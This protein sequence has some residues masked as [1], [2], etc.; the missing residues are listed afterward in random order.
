M[1]CSLP[2]RLLC[3]WNSPGKNTGMSSLSV[4]QGIFPSQG[5]NLGLPHCRWILYQLSHKGSP[6]IQE[7]VAVFFSSGSSR[8]RDWTQVSC[9]AGGFFTPWVT[10]EAQGQGLATFKWSRQ[11]WLFHVGICF[12]TSWRQTPTVSA[13][14]KSLQRLARSL[15]G[16]SGL[17]TC[18]QIS[19]K[20]RKRGAHVA[21]RE[22]GQW[23]TSALPW[24]GLTTR[25]CQAWPQEP[26]VC[27]RGCER[28]RFQNYLWWLA[29]LCS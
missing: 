29:G 27:P 23:C 13:P 22:P 3:P 2:A 24:D 11:K 8:P 18:E 26:L 20:G 1:G 10:R 7:W 6:R 15:W 16:D 17:E 19:G 14:V 12:I 21:C 25:G 28:P 9:M 4:L 5:S